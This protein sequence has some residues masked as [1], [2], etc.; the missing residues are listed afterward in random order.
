MSVVYN[1]D[2]PQI[3]STATPAFAFQKETLNKRMTHPQHASYPL[4]P[5]QIGLPVCIKKRIK[6]QCKNVLMEMD[7][8]RDTMAGICTE[9][10]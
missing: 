8:L 10:S 3:L 2:I 1:G 6:A 7:G 5:F 9:E 4:N